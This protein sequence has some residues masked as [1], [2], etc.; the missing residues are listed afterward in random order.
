M[1]L[2]P[3]PIVTSE[4]C[5]VC[6]LDWPRH[7]S[8][9][10]GKTCIDLLRADRDKALLQLANRPY[11]QPIPFVPHTP[12]P[13]TRPFGPYRRGSGGSTWNV[14]GI[15]TTNHTGTQALSRFGCASSTNA[16]STI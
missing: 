8:A 11:V 4:V 9:P 7:G 14:T 5:S 2:K 10:T 3:H 13:W 16:L 15:T 12:I 1:S 6:G